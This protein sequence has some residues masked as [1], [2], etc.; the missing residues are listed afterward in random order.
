MRGSK[1]KKG[2]KSP[3]TILFS[4]KYDIVDTKTG[5]VIE[6]AFMVIH[7]KTDEMPFLKVYPALTQK[8]IED[9]QTNRID[10]AV[11]LLFYIAQK[12]IE[13]NFNSEEFYISPT[14]ASKEIGISK[15]T[16]HKWLK[17]LAELGY[18]RKHPE[19]PK[20]SGWYV[21][22]PEYIYRGDGRAKRYSSLWQKA[23]LAEKPLFKEGKDANLQRKSAATK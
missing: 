16:I 2:R 19:Y 14:K 12:I 23:C 13:N 15:Q 6:Q 7:K 22:N 10:G 1:I 11:F 8:V 18:I 20:R 3:G 5:E 17:I 9:L 4:K 21:F